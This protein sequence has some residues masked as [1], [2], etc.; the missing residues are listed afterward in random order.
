MAVCIREQ[1]LELIQKLQTGHPSDDATSIKSAASNADSGRGASDEGDVRQ[2]LLRATGSGLFNTPVQRWKW[3]SGSWV[4]ASDP[5]THDDEI[6]VQYLAIFLFFVDI[7]KLL[8]TQLVAGDLILTYDFLL[9]RPRGLSS[10]TMPG[11]LLVPCVGVMIK[12]HGSCGSCGSWV[13]CV[14]GHIGHGSRK[15]THFHLCSCPLMLR[16]LTSCRIIIIYYY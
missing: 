14:M 2:R 13:N 3:V 4:T 12:G 11:L 9:S 16:R 6:T 7:K 5:L 15:M 1:V 10:T 8:L